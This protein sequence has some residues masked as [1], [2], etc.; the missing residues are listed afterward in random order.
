MATS[1]S[2]GEK[3]LLQN[4]MFGDVFF[5][6]GQS[7]MQFTLPSVFNATEEEAKANS[8]PHIRVMTVGQKTASPVPLTELKTIEQNWSVAY[9]TTIGGGNWTYFS[10][11][12]WLFGR[13]VYDSMLGAVPIGLVSTNWGGTPV[14]DWSSTDALNKCQQTVGDTQIEQIGLGNSQLYN[15]MIAPFLPMRA[16]GAIWYQGESNV[17]SGPQ[18]GG[19]YYACQFPAMIA[20]WRKKFMLENMYFGFVQL[21][22][23][24]AS[25]GTLVAELRTGQMAA[26][27]LPMV[28]MASAVDLGDLHSPFGSV[29]PRN[30]QTV[31]ARLTATA[32]ALLY[33]QNLVYQG[34]IFESAHVQDMH[35]HEMFDDFADVSVVVNFEP[36]TLGSGLVM[37]EA[38]CP[39]GLDYKHCAGFELQTSDQMWHN[40][41][42]TVQGSTLVV[43]MPME[44]MGTATVSGVRY[45]YGD[46]PIITIYNV[47]GFPAIPF[48]YSF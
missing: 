45:G 31:G 48:T 17:G 35:I 41:T 20:D 42:G 12:C 9:N 6:S 32:R 23:W 30:K 1:H 34:P 46:W 19:E 3:A 11:V 4:V 40:A 14:Q 36:S 33:K 26:L 28:G 39:E 43:S 37:K 7:N 8:Y 27:E 10:A 25:G 47:E 22:P 13:D 5:C 24:M 15:A 18:K 38:S 44:E 16:V 21:A 2:S 29:H